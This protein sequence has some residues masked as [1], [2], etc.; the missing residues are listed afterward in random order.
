MVRF[1]RCCNSPPGDAVTGWI[2][3]GRGVTVHRRGCQKA[4]ELDP[5][6]RVDVGWGGSA[7]VQLPVA[8]RVVTADRPGML[9]NVSSAFTESGVNITEANCRTS[10][11]GRAVNVFQFTVSDVSK[12]KNLM[13]SIQRIDG[14]YDVERV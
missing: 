8:M 3:R 5:E 11:D 14:V 1:A 7:N 12:L 10:A 2:T 9:A 4:M 6:R 13:R